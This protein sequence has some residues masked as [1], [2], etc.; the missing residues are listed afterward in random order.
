MYPELRLLLCP[1]KR[2]D[3]MHCQSEAVV[4]LPSIC[5]LYLP[6][7]PSEHQAPVFTSFFSYFCDIPHMAIGVN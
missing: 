5:S 6:T 2:D 7:D 3:Q 1:H 4:Q